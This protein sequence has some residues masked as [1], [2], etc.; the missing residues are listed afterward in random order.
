MEWLYWKQSVFSLGTTTF[1]TSQK[2]SII[3]L[4][5]FRNLLKSFTIL[6]KRHNALK[7][8]KVSDHVHWVRQIK[9]LWLEVIM[10]SIHHLDQGK[11]DLRKHGFTTLFY[12]FSKL[13]MHLW[14]WLS[15]LSVSTDI[16]A[17]NPPCYYR[18]WAFWS[19]Y[20]INPPPP[21]VIT[22][23]CNKGGL[24]A[25]ISVDV[26]YYQY[27]DAATKSKWIIL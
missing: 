18:I 8:F 1:R 7:L 2:L 25:R 24:F 21:L 3:A 14:R 15:W 9:T 20:A 12:D 22:Q 26:Q 16:L 17:I 27:D 11:S 6:L 10:Q 5:S 13:K 23:I 19:P 4:K